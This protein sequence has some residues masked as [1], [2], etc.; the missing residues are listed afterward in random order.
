[1]STIKRNV[2]IIGATGAVGEEMISILEERKFPVNDLFLFASQN[3]A[4]TS[5]SFNHKKYRVEV[6]K[7]EKL[8]IFGAI[9]LTLLSAGTEISQ[10]FIPLIAEKGTVCIDNSNAWRMDSDVPLVVPEVNYSDLNYFNRKNIVANPNCSTIQMV[11]V[12]K[13]IHDIFKITRVVVS[14]YQATSGKG[15]KAMGELSSQTIA[16]LNQQ[17]V[18]VKEFPHQIAFNCIPH[19]DSFLENGH[20]LEETKMILE[21]KKIMNAPSIRVSA[22]CVRVPVFCSHAE[23]VNIETEKKATPEEIRALL[24]ETKGIKVMDDPAKKLYPLNIMA[25]GKD[26]TLVGRIREDF[27]IANG[28]NLWIVSDNIRKGAALNAVQIA[29]ALHTE[30]L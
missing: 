29:E 9:D 19:I 15:K 12:L 16:L 26:D 20:T 24:S 25:T 11:Q 5:L 28:I 6:L 18:H 3:S 7:E 4:G 10:K 17:E 2:A 21:T 8:D 23:S 30:F 22:T 14:T 13:P 1:M 27:S